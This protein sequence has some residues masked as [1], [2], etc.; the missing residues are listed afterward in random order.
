MPSFP[1]D[2]ELNA[3]PAVRILD[4]LPV[5]DVST[6]DGPAIY[7]RKS[8]VEKRVAALRGDLL[9][10][11]ERE[12]LKR[13]LVALDTRI[14]ELKERQ[15]RENA[16]RNFAGIGSPLHEALVERLSPE[17][18]VELEA[19]AMAKLAEREQRSAERKATKA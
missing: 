8:L 19:E 14:R 12:T 17:L 4:G 3:S 13:E 15:K 16:R 10:T 9:R 5:A 11:A 2:R 18:V 7:A 6:L 1:E